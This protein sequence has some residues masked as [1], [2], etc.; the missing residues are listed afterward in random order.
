M[1]EDEEENAPAHLRM[2]YKVYRTVS[3]QDSAATA[4][5]TAI[6]YPHKW[7]QSIM[8]LE[9]GWIQPQVEIEAQALVKA[10]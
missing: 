2:Q 8:W 3:Y 10:S 6:S 1:P 9:V 7:L 5:Q 4:V